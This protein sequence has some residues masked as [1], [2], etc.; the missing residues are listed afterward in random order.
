MPKG[1]ARPTGS[2]GEAISHINMVRLRVTGNGS[3][4]LALLSQ[5]DV[6]RQQLHD[7]PLSART[8]IQPRTLAN[9]KEQRAKLEIGTNT[10]NDYF[11]INRI[12]LYSRY[13]ASEFP[14]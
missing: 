13:F 10:I 9:F 5:Q 1:T 14:G 7:I 2:S 4:K 6:S 8:A 3:L 12:I 11:R